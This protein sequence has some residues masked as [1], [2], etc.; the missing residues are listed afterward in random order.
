MMQEEPVEVAQ[1]KCWHCRREVG[2]LWDPDLNRNYCPA[3]DYT[4]PARRH[5]NTQLQRA[6]WTR[7]RHRYLDLEGVGLDEQ[8]GRKTDV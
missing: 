6:A 1:R 3:C 4:Q 8:R 7:L 2:I 5:P